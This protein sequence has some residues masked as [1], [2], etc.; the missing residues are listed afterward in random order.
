VV[1]L[2]SNAFCLSQ[3]NRKTAN[4]ARCDDHAQHLSS[5]FDIQN[6][7]YTHQGRRNAWISNQETTIRWARNANEG[8]HS[9]RHILSHAMVVIKVVMLV[10][11]RLRMLMDRT[12]AGLRFSSGN[13]DAELTASILRLRLCAGGR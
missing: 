12:M 9:I 7:E 8:G 13:S 5:I 6:A 11:M 3:N 1:V 10:R 4:G 2:S